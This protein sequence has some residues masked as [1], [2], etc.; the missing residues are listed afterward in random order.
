MSMTPF[1]DF[2]DLQPEEVESLNKCLP[3]RIRCS[4]KLDTTKS[5]GENDKGNKT[6]G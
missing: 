3:T 2:Q 6:N 1:V 4:L 5:R